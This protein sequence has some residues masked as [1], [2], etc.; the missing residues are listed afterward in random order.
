MEPG[1]VHPAG[2]RGHGTGLGV[3]L[4]IKVQSPGTG[5]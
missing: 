4:D 5:A 1:A 2:P 3:S